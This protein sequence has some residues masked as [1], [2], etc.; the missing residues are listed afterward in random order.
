MG[1]LVSTDGLIFGY[2]TGQTTSFLETKN[3]LCRFGEQLQGMCSFS[4]VRSGLI[5]GLVN[6]INGLVDCFP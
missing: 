4:E 5:A 6:Q 3:F 1:L 2:D